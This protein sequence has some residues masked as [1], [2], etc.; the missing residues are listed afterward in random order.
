MTTYR[1][2]DAH[3]CDFDHDPKDDRFY[4]FLCFA[5]GPTAL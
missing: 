2:S 1:E 5:S 3:T 4:A